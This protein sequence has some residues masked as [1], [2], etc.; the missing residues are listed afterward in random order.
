MR[1]EEILQQLKS[2]LVKLAEFN[3]KHLAIFG[4][5]AR[6]EA[7]ADSD[8]DVLVEFEGPATFDQYMGLKIFLE[9]LL[10][11]PVDL[12]TNKAV[13]PQL[14]PYIEREALRVA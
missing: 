1:R 13:R 14:A 6:D 7:R 9:D 11:L 8:V 3:V 4:S 2:Q 12:V 10:R 5:V